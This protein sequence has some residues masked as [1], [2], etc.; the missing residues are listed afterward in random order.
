M[1][2]IRTPMTS[3]SSLRSTSKQSMSSDSQPATRAFT[4]T[5]S[6]S[7]KVGQRPPANSG[8]SRED[9]KGPY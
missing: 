3:G 2:N 9:G 6:Y 7:R 4:P 5:D 8:P 1:P